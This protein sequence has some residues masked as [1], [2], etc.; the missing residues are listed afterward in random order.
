MIPSTSLRTLWVLVVVAMP[1]SFS[2]RRHSSRYPLAAV[3]II[4]SVALRNQADRRPR[5]TITLRGVGEGCVWLTALGVVV[6]FGVQMAC[7]LKVFLLP[8][9]LAV[10]LAARLAPL[11]RALEQ[12]RMPPAVATLA[13]LLGVLVAF[14]AVG[15]WIV[16]TVGDQVDE[17][18]TGLS[19][20]LEEEQ[21]FLVDS[22]EL[23]E[24]QIAD[25]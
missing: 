22:V 1:F 23:S 4:P 3:D 7:R 21:H 20:A 9:F 11:V 13:V 24:R 10:I 8:V 19:D 18:S 17:L 16:P 2:I 12:R 15:A 6:Y 25:A 5:T 14:G